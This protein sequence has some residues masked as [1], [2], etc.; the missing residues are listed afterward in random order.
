MYFS[1]NITLNYNDEKKH[2]HFP[3]YILCCIMGGAFLS[4]RVGNKMALI[5]P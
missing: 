2:I 4:E 1:Y 5:I 3:S